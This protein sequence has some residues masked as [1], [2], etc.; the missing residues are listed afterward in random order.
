MTQGVQIDIRKRRREQRRG[1]DN[2][3]LRTL[4]DS[5]LDGKC[6]ARYGLKMFLQFRGGGLLRR[7]GVFRDNDDPLGRSVLGQDRLARRLSRQKHDER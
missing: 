7:N 3:G 6:C 2:D 1:S 4:F 5:M